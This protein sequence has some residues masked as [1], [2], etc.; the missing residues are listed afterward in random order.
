MSHAR[1]LTLTRAIPGGAI[2][3]FC[4]PLTATSIPHASVSISIELMELTPS[5]TTTRPAS[6]PTRASSRSGLVRPVEVSLCVSRSSFAFGWFSSTRAR[7]SASTGWPHSNSSR[8]TSAPYAEARAANRSPKL[9]HSATT[10]SSPGETR[11]ATADS[12]PPVPD[13]VNSSRRSEEHTSELQSQSNIVCR[14]LLEKKKIHIGCA[15]HRTTLQRLSE[16]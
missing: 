8:T 15:N 9:P 7:S 16:I 5:T 11:L 14:L 2:H 3:P 4:E 6:R 13:E 12:R 1:S 10:T